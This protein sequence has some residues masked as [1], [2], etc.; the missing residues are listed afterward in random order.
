MQFYL[1]ISSHAAKSIR[2]SNHRGKPLRK[3]G[4]LDVPQVMATAIIKRRT[5]KVCG[6]LDIMI[7]VMDDMWRTTVPIEY[8]NEIVCGRCF[9]DLL[10][11]NRYNYCNENVINGTY[12][13]SK[14]G[15]K[16]LQTSTESNSD[17]R[18]SGRDARLPFS[19]PKIAFFAYP[20]ACHE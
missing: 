15:G 4:E 6:S 13:S 8:R 19:S 20:F 5:C 11:K 17:T 18:C 12:A 7:Q 16:R 14:C 1:M 10:L 2:F 9:E 3:I